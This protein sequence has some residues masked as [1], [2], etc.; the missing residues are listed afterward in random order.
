MEAG[1]YGLTRGMCFVQRRLEV[2]AVAG[3][4][5]ISWCVLGGVDSFVFFVFVFDLFFSSNAHGL[6]KVLGRLVSFTSMLVL[7]VP[8]S[9]VRHSS[10]VQYCLDIN[11][12]VGGAG[13]T[14]ILLVLRA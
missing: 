7:I 2:V 13:S 10:T 11:R 8:P 9:T 12:S 3:L 14:S 4:L 5:W 1:K 6:L